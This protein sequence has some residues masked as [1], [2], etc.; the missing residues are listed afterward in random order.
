MARRKK[1][2]GSLGHI[3]QDVLDDLQDRLDLLASS[4]YRY[5]S[6]GRTALALREGQRIT[7]AL[8]A[9][10]VVGAYC[11]CFYVTKKLRQCACAKTTPGLVDRKK[12]K[13]AAFKRFKTEASLSGD[14]TRSCRDEQGRFVPVSQCKGP[15]GRDPDTGRYISIK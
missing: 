4:E 3:T 10:E 9:A 12:R 8:Q 11:S 6:E 7:G 13:L 15:V 14:D 2:G 1:S 5:I